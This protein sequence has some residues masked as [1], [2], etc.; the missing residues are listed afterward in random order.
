MG[1]F[2]AVFIEIFGELAQNIQLLLKITDQPYK[3][4]VA[5]QINKLETNTAYRSAD[6]DHAKSSLCLCEESY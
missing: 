3:K 6:T 4:G 2:L 1:S 5:L